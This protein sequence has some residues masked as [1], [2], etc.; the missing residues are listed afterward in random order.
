VPRSP[1]EEIRVKVRS[2][3]I[4]GSRPGFQRGHFQKETQGVEAGTLSLRHQL[5][6]MGAYE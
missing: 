1:A 3:P 5:L 4:G 2:I 6:Q